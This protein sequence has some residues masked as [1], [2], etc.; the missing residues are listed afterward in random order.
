MSL[1]DPIPGKSEVQVNKRNWRYSKVPKT[2]TIAG[3]VEN[4]V[5]IICEDPEKYE[6]EKIHL[7]L[8]SNYFWKN[9]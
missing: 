1:I 6:R 4:K 9:N 7:V 5:F 2:L 8:M 3:N